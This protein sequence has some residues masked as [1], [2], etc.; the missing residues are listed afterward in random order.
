MRRNGDRR[1]ERRQRFRRFVS[2]KHA[3]STEILP[4]FALDSDL[5][6]VVFK[7]NSVVLTNELLDVVRG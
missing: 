1:R 4:E 3:D 6:D 5:D 7:Q 2:E